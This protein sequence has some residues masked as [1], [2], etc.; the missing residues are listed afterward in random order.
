MMQL[1]TERFLEIARDKA[2]C[3]LCPDIGLDADICLKC[4]KVK[5]VLNTEISPFWARVLKSECSCERGADNS[6]HFKCH[7]F[8]TNDTHWMIQGVDGHGDA[9]ACDM[10]FARYCPWCGGRLPDYRLH[11]FESEDAKKA[12]DSVKISRW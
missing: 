2:I 9:Y 7:M 5:G 3:D 11:N 6:P 8:P 10:P 4:K 12:V 1:T